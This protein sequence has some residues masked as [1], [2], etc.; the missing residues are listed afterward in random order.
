MASAA[1]VKGSGLILRGDRRVGL[2]VLAEAP[3]GGALVAEPAPVDDHQ[4]IGH[5]LHFGQDVA[6]QDHGG[7][8]L[9]GQALEQL[10]QVLDARGVQA[11]GVLVQDQ[12]PGLPHHGQGHAQPLAHAQ[13]IFPH[14]APEVPGQVHQARP[15]VHLRT[16]DP[17]HQP[18]DLQVLPAG[19]V[20]LQGGPLHHGADL[21][22]RRGMAGGIAEYLA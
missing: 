5:L 9:P 7:L 8:G 21:G 16:G 1:I 13:G 17:A 6:G 15:P 12:Q 4:V 10:A 20:V 2:M 22:Q 3:S 11:V 18:G 19:Q 14:R